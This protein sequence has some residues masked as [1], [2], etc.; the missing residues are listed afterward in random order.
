MLL[1]QH[2][3][4]AYVQILKKIHALRKTKGALLYYFYKDQGQR[5]LSGS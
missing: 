1:N 2:L 4:D 3:H 5:D